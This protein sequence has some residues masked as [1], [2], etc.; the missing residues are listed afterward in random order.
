M[1]RGVK[2]F[3]AQSGVIGKARG[4]ERNA[5]RPIR[6]REPFALERMPD[7]VVEETA[8]ILCRNDAVTEVQMRAMRRGE[9]LD[10]HFARTRPPARRLR[11]TRQFLQERQRA[12][13]KRIELER[14]DFRRHSEFPMRW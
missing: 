4:G 5:V 3:A 6:T 8:R 9:P 14:V 12:Q 13:L 7:L 2:K 10:R 1:R 11:V